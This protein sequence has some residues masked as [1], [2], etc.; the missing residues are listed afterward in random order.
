[1]TILMPAD[2]APRLIY[3]R[4][5]GPAVPAQFPLATRTTVTIPRTQRQLLAVTFSFA[6]HR[7]HWLRQAENLFNRQGLFYFGFDCAPA[8]YEQR[9]HA[10]VRLGSAA[11]VLAQHTLL[12]PPVVTLLYAFD[13]T[14]DFGGPSGVT[15]NDTV[16]AQGV[17]VT[18]ITTPS[19]LA[20][21]MGTGE[22][23]VTLET[24][25]EDG[26]YEFDWAPGNCFYGPTQSN[27]VATQ[28]VTLRVELHAV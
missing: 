5:V 27:I 12:C 10:R 18:T 19:V 20:N 25:A 11:P 6:L 15:L 7:T 28:E 9:T 4:G 2:P 13:G 21:F 16:E 8:L 22:Q 14:L 3:Y 17:G 1:M 26:N 23:R 24:A